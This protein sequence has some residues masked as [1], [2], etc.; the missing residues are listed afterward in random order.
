MLLKAHAS[1][2]AILSQLQSSLR[3]KIG[4]GICKENLSLTL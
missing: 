1:T 3:K 4:T 2:E